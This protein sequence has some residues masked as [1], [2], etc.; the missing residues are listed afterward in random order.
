MNVGPASDG[1]I[2]PIFEERLRQFGG[3]L[4]VNGEGIY[5]T[6]PWTHQND[7]ITSGVW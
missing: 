7:T 3:W 4:Q 1:M 5:S 2:V 6:K